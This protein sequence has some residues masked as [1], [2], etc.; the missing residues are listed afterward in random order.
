MNRQKI[1]F[2]V[3]VGLLLIGVVAFQY[4]MPPTL[5]GAVIEPPKPMP[6][7][8]PVVAEELELEEEEA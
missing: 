5:H 4:T 8:P 6:T 3:L 7:T 2:A 1:L